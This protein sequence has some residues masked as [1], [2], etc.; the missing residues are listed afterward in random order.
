MNE[1]R[2][3]AHYIPG[4]HS[5]QMT[6]D[7]LTRYLLKEK[8]VS[9]VMDL[10]CG[11]GDSVE[12]FRSIDQSIEWVGLDVEQSPEVDKRKRADAAFVSYDGK[13]IPFGDSHFDLYLLQSSI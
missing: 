8:D 9:T 13:T 5:Q 10:G 4:N 2:L 1:D 11:P 12:F 3:A 6:S 7:A